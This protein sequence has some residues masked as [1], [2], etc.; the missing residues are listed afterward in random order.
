M[1]DPKK[2]YNMPVPG[3]PNA[4]I[5]GQW[6][7]EV[8]DW[9]I[10]IGTKNKQKPTSA[11]NFKIE[12]WTPPTPTTA[13]PAP[14]AAAPAAACPCFDEA[15]LTA[16]KGQAGTLTFTPA[17][18]VATIDYSVEG[19]GIGADP[20]YWRARTGVFNPGKGPWCDFGAPTPVSKKGS[21]RTQWLSADQQV[22]CK[23]ILQGWAKK[24][25]GP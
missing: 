15:A 8:G 1:K 17:G 3:V 5:P 25:G 22:V 9:K 21:A 7:L 6:L 18:K 14:A 10:G 4:Y 13:A 11:D 12:D 2:F 23:G 19:R 20:I 16:A 24:N